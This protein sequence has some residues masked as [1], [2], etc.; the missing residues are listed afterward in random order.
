MTQKKLNYLQI[1]SENMEPNTLK[2]I[3]TTLCYN[4]HNIYINILIH[5]IQQHKNVHSKETLCSIK[6]IRLNLIIS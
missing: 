4:D 6:M 1:M 3:K 5:S 2:T